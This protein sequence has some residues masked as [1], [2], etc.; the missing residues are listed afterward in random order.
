[1]GYVHAEIELINGVDLGLARKNIIG[2][3]E[4]KRMFITVLVDSGCYTLAI[5]E[6]IQEILQ[7][8]VEGKK[9]LQ[10]ADGTIGEF[11]VVAPVKIKFKNRWCVCSAYVLPGNS[12]PLL[13]VIPLEEM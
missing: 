6:C 2:E 10:L 5:N 1:M 12:E 13:G 4:I 9:P 8:P 7:L 3:K 11:D